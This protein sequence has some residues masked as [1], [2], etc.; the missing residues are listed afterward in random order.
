[1]KLKLFP[2]PAIEDASRSPA[3]R[4]IQIPFLPHRRVSR[5]TAWWAIAVGV[6]PVLIYEIFSAGAR[7]RRQVK[8]AKESRRK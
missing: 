4:S 7:E 3:D 1:M 6:W 2:T 5:K 8:R